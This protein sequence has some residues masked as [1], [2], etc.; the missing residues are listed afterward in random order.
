[1]FGTLEFIEALHDVILRLGYISKTL[2]RDSLEVI[3]LVPKPN[4]FII[5]SFEVQAN[6]VDIQHR[7]VVYQYAYLSIII[8]SK[9]RLRRLDISIQLNWRLRFGIYLTS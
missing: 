3:E 4:V 5:T 1:M 7:V 9:M 6:W 2:I 8:C